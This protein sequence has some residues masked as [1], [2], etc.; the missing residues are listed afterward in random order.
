MIRKCTVRSFW[1]NT[2]AVSE[3]FTSLPALSVVLIGFSLFVILLAQTY[4]A[5]QERMAQVEYF[6]IAEGLLSKCTNPD[7]PFMKNGL[8]DVIAASNTTLVTSMQDEY[9]FSNV[10]FVLRLQYLDINRDVPEPPPLRASHR[11]A[12]SKEI[13]VSLNDAQT[14]P[15]TLTLILWRTA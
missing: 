2:Q 1:S 6:Q 11:I 7:S 14:I 8:I 15:G 10:S 13:G 12:A 3:E 5:Y 4:T 9:A